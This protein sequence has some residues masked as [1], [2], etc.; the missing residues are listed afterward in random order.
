VTSELG[1]SESLSTVSG[2]VLPE[3]VT[4]F[5]FAI[6]KVL[7]WKPKEINDGGKSGLSGPTLSSFFRSI[8]SFSNFLPIM[9]ESQAI[10]RKTST[11]TQLDINTLP[12]YVIHPIDRIRSWADSNGSMR[13]SKFFFNIRAD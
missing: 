5:R 12:E 11:K 2:S 7:G 1:L 10:T 8:T 6:V 13:R 9:S 3:D 4:S